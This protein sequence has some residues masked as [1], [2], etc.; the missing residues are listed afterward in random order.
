MEIIGKIGTIKVGDRYPIR[1]VGIVNLSPESF[2]KQDV[3]PK[4]LEQIISA[5]IEENADVLDLGGQSTAPIQIYG[6]SVRVGLE[7]ELRRVKIG[8]KILSDL[9]ISSIQISIDSLRSKVAEYALNN[10]ATIVNDIS[11]LKAD[12]NMAKV[13]SDHNASLVVMATDK[14]PGDVWTI[15]SIIKA[16]QESVHRGINA[17]IEPDRIMVDPGI[18][19]WGGRAF[20]HD[21]TILNQLGNF[22]ELKMPIYVGVSRK[23]FIGAILEKP[24]IER[25][26][27]SLAATAIAVYNGAHIIRTHD[28]GVSRDTIKIAKRLRNEALNLN[29]K[30]M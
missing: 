2:Y 17:N 20:H 15:E 30:K 13:I 18:G 27:G 21:Y 8:F 3:S 24:P 12:E 1:L 25:L 22:R 6:H 4:G 7:E 11:G 5:H 9:N 19:S 29:L 23:S 14:E 10:G 16:L 26:Q 28:I